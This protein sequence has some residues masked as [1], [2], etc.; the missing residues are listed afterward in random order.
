MA[1]VIDVNQS[2]YRQMET[3]GVRLDVHRAKLLADRL[4]C[5]IDELL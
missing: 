4:N 3:G 5:T 2:H 1:E